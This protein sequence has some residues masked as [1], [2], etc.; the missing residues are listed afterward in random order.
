MRL[1]V[2]MLTVPSLRRS[3][4]STQMAKGH[5]RGLMIKER[6][7]R[8]GR[9]HLSKRQCQVLLLQPIH[10]LRAKKESTILQK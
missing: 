9:L 7:L 10:M 8:Q 1:A 5:Q 4:L 2:I 3:L 6:S